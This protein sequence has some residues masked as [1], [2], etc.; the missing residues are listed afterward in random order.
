MNS[1]PAHVRGT[2]AAGAVRHRAQL[3]FEA[4]SI[5]TLLERLAIPVGVRE[6]GEGCGDGLYLW[7]DG[8]PFIVINASNRP[9]RQRFTAAHELGH[10]E[11]HRHEH[12]RQVFADENIF[13]STELQEVEANAFA[14]Y[15]LAP[16][17]ALRQHVGERSGEDIDPELV[18]ELMGAFGLSYDATTY[19]LLNADLVNRAQR[20][21]LCENPMVEERMRRA[22]IDEQGNFNAPPALPREH[23]NSTLKLYEESVITP[24]RLG[25]LLDLP[26]EQALELARTR[27]V[28]PAAEL[29][30]DAEAIE[31]LMRDA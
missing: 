2:Q 19:R 15:L 29:E 24:Q 21:R 30:V 3:G 18:V 16:D 27:G 9:S 20:E 22:G 26:A 28:E 10:H 1:V 5:W 6:F 11:M 25:E 17:E 4:L 14:A 7:D 31:E 8:E 12:E 13:G 23:I